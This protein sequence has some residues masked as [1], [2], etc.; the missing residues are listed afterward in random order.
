MISSTH[1][2]I[3]SKEDI[4]F[5]LLKII[6]GKD[7]SIYILSPYYPADKAN[8]FIA[9]IN[10]SQGEID[11]PYKE[12]KDVSIVDDDQNRLKL[13]HHV[14]GFIQVSGQ[15]I[16]SGL[17]E[18]GNP[19]GIGMQSYPLS[20]PINGPA[21]AVTIYGFEHFKQVAKAKDDFHVF[22][23][24]AFQLTERFKA[25]RIE[26]YFF[27]ADD[28]RFIRK[29]IDGRAI[30][31]LLHPSGRIIPL[32]VALPPLDCI[33]QTFIS[34]ELYFDLGEE[35]Q[36]LPSFFLSSSTGNIRV[37]EKCEKLGDGIFIVYPEQNLP[38]AKSLNYDLKIV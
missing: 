25:L 16:I 13:S 11:V 31:N 3:L 35:E 22:S 38:N 5:K 24:E 19:K 28:R 37:N 36:K 10:Y 23:W 26:G 14:S 30:I 17:D 6:Y 12:L 18:D 33:N 1:T 32:L 27:P 2:V 7:G 15:G 20:E 9:T 29:D 34:I 4:Y 21:F 8:V